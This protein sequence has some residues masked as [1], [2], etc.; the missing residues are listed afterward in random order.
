[1]TSIT[2]PFTDGVNIMIEITKEIFGYPIT[3]TATPAGSDWNVV[4]LG[5]CTPH[6]GSVS[7]A[8]FRD[9]TVALRT[10]LRDT[11][12]DQIVGERFARILARQQHCTV[13]VSCGI[14][15]HNPNPEDLKQIVSVTEILLSE[16]CER[17]E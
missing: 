7:L 16:L 1:M 13:C 15:F 8:E 11:H 9:N 6:V 5:G 2:P 12:K 17:I 10:L 4:I 3:V 14:H